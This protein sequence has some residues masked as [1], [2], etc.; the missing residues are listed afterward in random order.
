MV[1]YLRYVIPFVRLLDGT[2]EL[3]SNVFLFGDGNK[4]WD[5]NALTEVLKRLT[6]KGLGFRMTNNLY[7]H[8][9][10]AIDRRHIRPNDLPQQGNPDNDGEEEDHER[11]AHDVMAAHSKRIGDA[12]YA[13][14][15][16]LTSS[17]TPESI[18]VS[19]RVCDRSHLWLNMAP[20]D[21]RPVV[22]DRGNAREFTRDELK[23]N[24]E[25]VM[26]NL[27]G[28]DWRWKSEEQ[29]DAVDKT[30]AG[31]SP[32]F[33]ILPTGGGKTLSF[34]VAAKMKRA[35]VTVIVTP[36]IAL[37]ED[38]VRRFK[39]VGLDTILY[40]RH[41]K[42]RA[43][44]VVVV[45]EKAGHDEF[46]EFMRDIQLEG[47][48]DRV[49]YDEA[50]KL[51]SD[52]S[53]RPYISRSKE[54]RL[55]CQLM[56]ITATCPPELVEEICE[57][58]VVPEPHIIRAEY[59][60]PSFIYQVK[61]CSKLELQLREYLSEIAGQRTE[62]SKCL[63]FCRYKSQVVR[64]AR[65]YKARKYYSGQRDNRKELELWNGGVM[66]AT[67]ALGAGVDIMGIEDVVH[68]ECPYGL[69]GYAQESGR[70]GLGDDGCAERVLIS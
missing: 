21:E 70:G 19:R 35:G 18:D 1:S 57:E 23:G 47:C 13:R 31:I 17:L 44:V 9:S 45:T 27:Y 42:R 54:L 34:M 46:A 69:L 49:V 63:V 40:S 58:M 11:D 55:R 51:I 32:L 29:R 62:G 14:V 24:I 64:Y 3:F 33:I 12:I 66:F 2:R 15:R 16:N 30:I 4:P 25:G 59:Y 43:K 65:E 5:T 61:V 38:L 36:L 22:E 39:E 41:C 8:T 52:Q 67:T 37:G 50:H 28:E 20:R 60:K 53:Y 26:R 48:L 56:F 10:I 7:R 68:L 6:G